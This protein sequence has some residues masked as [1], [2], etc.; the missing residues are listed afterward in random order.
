VLSFLGTERFEVVR[1]LGK[2]SNGIVYE[3]RDRHRNATVALKTLTGADGRSLYDFKKEFRALQ[4]VAHENVIALRELFFHDGFWFFTMDLVAGID[5]LSWVRPGGARDDQ[6]LRSCLLQL[7]T[8][9]EALHA[10]KILHRDLK[11]SNVMVTEEGRVVILDFGLVLD[12]SQDLRA[13]TRDVI[14]G[15]VSY[16][17]PEQATMSPVEAPSD[18]YAFGVML[19]EALAGRVP[20]AGNAVKVLIAKVHKSPDPPSVHASDIP[21]DLER[22]CVELL[23]IDPSARPTGSEVIDRLSKS[24]PAAPTTSS[25]EHFAVPLDVPFVGRKDE[26]A[27]L[28]TALEQSRDHPVAVLVRGPSGAG[29]TAL[30]Q[31]FTSSR[32]AHGMGALVLAGRCYER[33]WLPHKALDS[34][35][36]GLVRHLRRLAPEDATA[37]LPREVDALA[38]V[39]PALLRVD[40]VEVA[41][42]RARRS[43]SH[44]DVRERA[45]HA[46]KDLLGRLADRRPVVL[47]IDDLQWGDADSAQLVA[48]LFRPPAPASI[49]FLGSHR[50]DGPSEGSF[51]P[52]FRAQLS[53]AIE[54][55]LPPFPKADTEALIRALVEDE[56]LVER[57]MKIAHEAEGNAFLIVEIARQMTSTGGEQIGSLDEVIERRATNLQNEARELLEAIAVAGRP[58]TQHVAFE[59]SELRAQGPTMLSLLRSAH[60]IQTSG[61]G[62]NDFVECY[63]D[64]IREHF[65]AHCEHERTVEIHRRLLTALEADQLTDPE[66]LFVHAQS[67]N[68]RDKAAEY[69]IKAA[70][71]AEEKLAFDRAARLYAR[72][73]ELVAPDRKR[74]RTLEI[75][76]AEALA[77]AGRGAEAAALYLECAKDADRLSKLD[78]QRRAAHEL[79]ASGHIDAGL[80]VLDGLLR[81]VGMRPPKTSLSFVGA[82]LSGR[83]AL[84]RKSSGFER[85][86]ESEI[87]PEVLLRVD[88]CWAAAVPLGLINPKLS[89][90][91]S[92]RHTR[93]AIAVGEPARIA[94]G[95]LH[96]ALMFGMGGDEAE[97]RI[98]FD[99]AKRIVDEL[100]H[101]YL[102]ALAALTRGG[103]LGS[104]GKFPEASRSLISAQSIFD[105]QVPSA[106]WERWATLLLE[107]AATYYCGEISSLIARVPQLVRDATVRG[108]R[109]LTGHMSDVGTF[110][111]AMDATEEASRQAAE[112]RMAL[113]Q[114]T[115]S[116]ASYTDLFGRSQIALYTG[117]GEQSAEIVEAV[118][119]ELEASSLL[120]IPFLSAEAQHLRARCAIAAARG[121]N[122]D[123]MIQRAKRLARKLTAAKIDAAKALGELL[124]GSIAQ[125]DEEAVTHLRR[126]VDLFRA[127]G[128]K[129]YLAAAEIRLGER[130]GGHEG[131]SL[132]IS[133]TSFMESQGIVKPERMTEMLAPTSDQ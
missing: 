51:L 110:W 58:I 45:S 68:A 101:P 38:R 87:D 130:L 71:Q 32:A 3:A 90:Y 28:T 104:A 62:P 95:L 57:A 4:D 59:A 124:L 6:R 118:W 16:M 99:R 120:R 131:K 74:V 121:V 129:L 15:T 21:E 55:D 25:R 84:K 81:E 37:V 2:G 114:S 109:Y 122:R 111:L 108:N 97:S 47:W 76:R 19:Y 31:H 115:F 56:A 113:K 86:A 17:S 72:A 1:C 53:S 116:F 117:S 10:K 40:A 11:P 63:H 126:T 18:W 46:L 79:L 93:L 128:M 26:L 91:H 69:A 34:T 73:I 96:A 88:T 98:L 22:L 12:M 48:Q 5:F 82:I 103:V 75:S 33:E 100:Q 29:K 85:K 9:L 24:A 106:S 41:Q 123:P 27:R 35:I 13:T 132:V 67:A 42:K 70:K 44:Q 8:G 102:R 64:K 39:F 36:D 14:A 119:Q 20:F 61:A 77:N 83:L 7:A 105:A 54:L 23:S 50:S 89:M 52:F 78:L 43:E 30:L 94:R 60:L 65:A 107:L 125:R 66:A 92:L 112:A 49:L 133:G 80:E 127:L